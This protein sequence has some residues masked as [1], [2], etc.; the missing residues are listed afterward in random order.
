MKDD[1]EKVR[2]PSLKAQDHRKLKEIT[3]QVNTVM[4]YIQTDNITE[5]NNLVYAGAR[6]VVELMGVKIRPKTPHDQTQNKPAWMRSQPPWKRR[7]GKQV[8]ELRADLSKLKEMADKKLK[9]KKKKEELNERY[10]IQAK[11][12]NN[13]IE[14]LKQRIKAKS[15]KIQRYSNRNKGYQQNKLFNLNQKRLY[16]QL[17]GENPQQDIPEAE[18]TKRL[19]EGIWGSPVKHKQTEWLRELKEEECQRIRQIFPEITPATVKKQVRKIPN[20]KAPGP[21]GVNGYWIKNFRELHGRIAQQLEVCIRNHKAPTWMTLGRTSL[22]QKDK[23]KGTIPTNYRPITCLPIMW[24]LLTG[25]ISDRL[26]EYLEET[27]TIPYQQKGGR[28]KCRGTKDQLLIDKMIMKNSKRRK[29][30][31][32]MAWIDYKKAFDMIPH[33]WLIEC[34]EIYGADTDVIRFIKN[35]MPNWKTVL[36][37]SGVELAEVNIKRGIFQ[38][39]SLSP[40]LFII[41]L[42]PMT[43]VLEKTEAGYQLQKGSRRINHLMFMDDIK[44]FG[45]SSGE[46]DSLTQTVRIVSNDIKM[47]FGIEKCGVVNIHK[48]KTTKTEGIK[49]PDGQNIKDVS[50]EGYKYL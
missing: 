18:P 35:T 20:W 3:N 14:D 6:L 38:G 22:I 39:D 1:R 43:R 44:L 32:S 10:N 37:S 47:E 8:A 5:T 29:T 34:L 17:N 40:L 49:L 30:N 28:R 23:N 13:I 48:G 25:I 19:W 11:G 16:S 36:T 33:S 41:A 27:H 24:K 45:R 9:N 42:I 4:Q 50:D 31:L 7:L 15:F 21:D 46:I 26:Y 2:L 12:L